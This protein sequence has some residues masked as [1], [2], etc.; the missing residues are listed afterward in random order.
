MQ[1]VGAPGTLGWLLGAAAGEQQWMVSILG[2]TG[3]EKPAIREGML[4]YLH[5]VS[6]GTNNIDLGL[7]PDDS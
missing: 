1:Q 2:L 3:M 5:W 7:C 4:I 6:S